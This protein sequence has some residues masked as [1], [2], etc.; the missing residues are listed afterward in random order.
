MYQHASTATE[1]VRQPI[2]HFNCLDGVPLQLGSWPMYHLADVMVYH[3][4]CIELG[5]SLRPS[6]IVKHCD[7]FWR[8]VL[9]NFFDVEALWLRA[10]KP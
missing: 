8:G 4:S 10:I 7:T 5:R 9:T 6:N 1:V 3:S 2:Y